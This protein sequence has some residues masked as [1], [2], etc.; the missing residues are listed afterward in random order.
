MALPAAQ[1]SARHRHCQLRAAATEERP[2]TSAAEAQQVSAV[3]S[4][5]ATEACAESLTACVQGPW[6]AVVANADFMLHDVQNESFA[7]QL[8][9]RRRL[10]S[11]QGREVDFFLV[12][13]PAWLEEG[14]VKGASRVRRPSLAVV[15]QDKQWITCA[16]ACRCRLQAMW[17]AG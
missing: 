1:S 2:Q 7:E 8:R 17:A 5:L 11:E 12:P 15:S 14:K 16:Q 4:V 3:C 6:Y 9:E 13:E 10:Y